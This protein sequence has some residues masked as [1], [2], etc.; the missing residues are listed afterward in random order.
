MMRLGR[1]KICGGEEEAMMIRILSYT[2][3][4]IFITVVMLTSG[5]RA[6]APAEE[7]AKGQEQ[8]PPKDEKAKSK[9]FGK[10]FCAERSIAVKNMMVNN[11]NCNDVCDNV[12]QD[13]PC[14]LQRRLNDGWK[15]T[16]VSVASMEVQRDPCE[17]SL[18]GT[19]STLER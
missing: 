12:S 9:E 17:C 16:S 18:T 15:V 13:Y 7:P 1:C 5:L 4:V 19:E 10:V 8:A 11:V 14:E 2:C 3:F 6:Q